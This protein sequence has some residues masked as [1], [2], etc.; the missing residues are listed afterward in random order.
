MSDELPRALIEPE[1]P[2][3]RNYKIGDPCRPIGTT[4]TLGGQ[5]VWTVGIGYDPEHHAIITRTVAGRFGQKAS[6]ADR[7]QFGAFLAVSREP[8]FACAPDE[9]AEVATAACPDSM[10]K[11]TRIV[12]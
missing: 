10:A 5:P 4:V 3:C 12:R 2:A 7:D 6:S 1:E 11:P 8:P 9:L